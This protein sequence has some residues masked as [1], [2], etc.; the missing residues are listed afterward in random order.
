MEQNK[1]NVCTYCKWVSMHTCTGRSCREAI[2]AAEKRRN[3]MAR[4]TYKNPDGTF[5]LNNGY[6]MQKVPTEL[7]GAIWKLKNYEETG[8]DP[9]RVEE[10]NDFFNSQT[11]KILAE[12]QEYKNLGLT[13]EQL[14]EI[15]RLY[16]EKCQELNRLTAEL[17]EYKQAATKHT[18][19]DNVY[20]KIL[21]L[22]KEYAENG[23]TE[24]VSRCIKSENLMQYFKE[25]L[26]DCNAEY[27][28]GWVP[29]QQRELTEEEKA[30]YGKDIKYMLDCKLP[31]EDEEIL[32]TYASGI[33]GIDTF[34]RDGSEC[35]L[36]S[37]NDFITEAIAW[38]PL[39]EQY[40]E[41]E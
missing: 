9:E 40:Q 29:F 17:E 12:L 27:N 5:G 37:G 13:L 7:Y 26:R 34:M 1:E 23:D 6:D 36:D 8:L 21:N 4:L 16:L 22:E 18:A 15:D 14:K 2:A 3:E 38:Q 20:E 35:Y 39:P 32:I 31:E 33:V 30:F 19:F 25:E 24:N 10:I 11:A 41:G 28:N